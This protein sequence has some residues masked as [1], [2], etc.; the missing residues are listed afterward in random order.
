MGDIESINES[1]SLT[2]ANELITHFN[3]V[4]AATFDSI[5]EVSGI[6]SINGLFPNMAKEA[7]KSLDRASL[8]FLLKNILHAGVSLRENL[9]NLRSKPFSN[10]NGRFQSVN[11]MIS[12]IADAFYIFLSMAIGGRLLEL[13]KADEDNMASPAGDSGTHDDAMSQIE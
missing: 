5:Q 4:I 9:K 10:P 7:V 3:G 11:D 13:D 8:I 12:R 1:I 2:D 6:N